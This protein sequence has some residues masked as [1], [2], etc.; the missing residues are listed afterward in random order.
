MSKKKWTNGEISSLC[1]ELSLLLHAG[2]SAADGLHLLSED[3]E[4][5]PLLSELSRLAD[6]GAPLSAVLRSGGVFPEYVCALTACGERTGRTEE[7]LRALSEYYD[8]RERLEGRVR[9]ALLYPSVLLVL[10]LVV[11]TVLLV[12]VL[13]VFDEVYASLGGQLTGLA[14]GLLTLG[15]A[16]DAAMPVL[17]AVLAVAA[18]VLGAFAVSEGFRAWVLGRWRSGPRG[19]RGLSRRLDTA[20][21]AQALAM[22][23]SSGLPVEEAL[24]LAASLGGGNAAAQRRCRDCLSR[25]E[26]GAGLAE[27]LR[28][29]DLL[30]PA[31]CR[32]LALG[33]RSGSGDAVMNELANRLS[34]ESEAAVEAAVSRVEPTL[35]IVT[36]L[37]VGA[38][39]L[40]VMLPLMNIMAAIG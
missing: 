6:G 31:A 35:V 25:L 32:M 21:F 38:I 2:L 19:D 33:I 29:S 7:A 23:L 15:R 14:G 11:I 3:E 13:P 22:G 34:E 17:L 27:A 39:L 30:P 12:R 24:E 16:L 10:M 36:S 4:S 37:L 18:A 28:Q 1:M 40:S 5:D 8:G 26:Q 9:S 20:R